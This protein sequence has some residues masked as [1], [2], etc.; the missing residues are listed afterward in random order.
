MPADHSG[1]NTVDGF[2]FAQASGV[3]RSSTAFADVFA[4]ESTDA[5]DFLRFSGGSV[6]ANGSTVLTFGIRDYNGNRPFLLALGA[7]GLNAATPEPGTVLLLGTGLL[8]LARAARR[9]RHA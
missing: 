3:G 7:N 1:S 4:D 9:R 8:G 6:L 5:R 2:S